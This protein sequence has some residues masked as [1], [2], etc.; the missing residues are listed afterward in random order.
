MAVAGEDSIGTLEEL[1]AQV[2]K[3][4]TKTIPE[5]WKGSASGA[6]LEVWNRYTGCVA[7]YASSLGTWC[8]AMRVAA[9]TTATARQQLVAAHHFATRNNLRITEALSIAPRDAAVPVQQE[10]VDL[11][12]RQLDTAVRTASQARAQIRA[13][14]D[15]YEAQRVELSVLDL[16][17]LLSRRP[18]GSRPGAV[19]GKGGRESAKHLTVE[20]RLYE[21]RLHLPAA[22][23]GTWISGVPGNGTWMPHRPGD[24]GLQWPRDTVTW[25][26]GSPNLREHGPE[27]HR[28][29]DGREGVLY[30]VRGLDGTWRTDSKIAD[31]MLA[32]RFGW[33]TE[34]V[35]GWRQQEGL[36]WHHYTRGEMQLV[37]A[38]IH[39]SVP[40][41]GGA[42]DLRR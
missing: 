8:R 16:L 37:P 39:N 6:V 4:V 14:N 35:K 26:N 36:T 25:V 31:G 24:F 15:A 17:D 10:V 7:T 22:R 11:A 33:T 42:T 27:T 40:H 41:E 28:M 12:S 5:R 20:E 29:P 19:S 1:L 13:A 18:S 23:W 3:D 21:G 38:R 2:S 34:A 9:E 32:D 30:D